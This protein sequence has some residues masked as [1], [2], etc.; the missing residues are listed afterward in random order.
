MG[1]RGST[2]LQTL[3]NQQTESEARVAGSEPWKHKDG[4]PVSVFMG[5]GVE[6]VRSPVE[7]QNKD[8]RECQ[9]PG[10]QGR[11]GLVLA[12]Q[13]EGRKK[14]NEGGQQQS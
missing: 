5:H 1:R 10:P 12:Q 8:Q 6:E 4:P 13:D 7:T 14:A 11:A 3:D 9:N 2:P